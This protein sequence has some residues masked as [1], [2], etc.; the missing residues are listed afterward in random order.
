MRRTVEALNA[1]HAKPVL[2]PMRLHDLRHVHATLLLKA[3]VQVHVVAARLGHAD[4]RHHL[5]VYA[6]V[7]RATRP[8][9]WPRS[10]PPWS[11]S[12]S[13]PPSWC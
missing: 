6:H 9:R 8:S 13:T 3:G 2:P 1:G 10:S 4:P 7:L 11:T 12:P 5:R